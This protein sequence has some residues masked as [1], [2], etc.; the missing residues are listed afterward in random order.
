MGDIDPAGPAAA[1][2]HP[3][4]RVLVVDDEAFVRTSLTR[5]LGL[6]HD[7]VG[8]GDGR[9]ALE[10]LLGGERFDAVL[11]DLMMPS[12]SGMELHAALRAEAPEAARRMV[13]MT[14]GVFT[15]EAQ[16]FLASVENPRIDK[17]FQLEE[18]RALIRA[19]VAGA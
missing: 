17:P 4:G 2:A 8:L 14:G 13:F 6:E 3:R 10:L 11:C 1:P 5:V 16:A 15:D 9:E 7:V 12:V 18:I 19:L